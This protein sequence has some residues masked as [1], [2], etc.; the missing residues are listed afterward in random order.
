MTKR[1]WKIIGLVAGGGLMLQ[2]GTCAFFLLQTVGQQ[3]L[4][5]LLGDLFFQAIGGD[6]GS[7]TT[8]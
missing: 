5:G 1:M 2:F 7:T 3:I 6:T 4:F 8:P